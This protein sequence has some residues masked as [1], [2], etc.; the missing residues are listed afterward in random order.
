[1]IYYTNFNGAVIANLYDLMNRL[2]AR[3]YPNGTSNTFTYTPTG[4]RQTMT[5][6]S[7]SYT[8]VYDSRDRLCT[9]TTPLGT[10]SY[11]YDANGNVTSIMSSTIGGTLVAYQYDALNRLTNVVDSRLAGATNTAYD[12]DAVGNLQGIQYPNSVASQ[13]QYDSLNRLTSLVWKTNGTPIASFAYTLGASGNRTALLETNHTVNTV[14][15]GYA[16]NYDA[17]Y[18][19]TSETVT[20]AVPTG[21]IGY[22]YDNVGNRTIRTN[23]TSGL[24]LA[25][26]SFTFNTNDWLTGDVYDSNGNTRTNASSQPYFYDYENRLINFN[27]GQVIIVYD[28]DGNRVK[29]IT[30]TT[31]TLYLVDTHNPSGYAQVLEEFT[32]SG[33][34]TNL[35]KAY[36]Y[37]L[38]LISQRTLNPQP[39]T[40]YFVY[41]GHGSTRLL[42]DIGGNF[43]N[44]FAYDAYGNLIASNGVPQTAYLYCCQQWDPDLSQYYNR[45]RTWQP[46]TGRFWTMDSYTGNNEDPLSLHKYLYCQAD[47]INHTDPSGHDVYKVVV[48]SKDDMR[49]FWI[50]PIHHRLIVGDD[51][52][53]GSYILEAGGNG[54]SSSRTAGISYLH[55]DKQPATNVVSKFTG[56]ASSFSWTGYF[57]D[58]GL[59]V[60][61]GYVAGHVVTTPGTDAVLDKGASQMQGK[62][63][64][65]MFLWND[66]GTYANQWLSHSQE[67]EK[68]A[69]YPFFPASTGGVNYVHYTSEI[70]SLSGM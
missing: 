53:G 26:Q 41:D 55:N 34:V 14:I 64:D 66:C 63:I 16:W 35:A 10:L 11:A 15:R 17:M 54:R 13:Y 36:T 1:L 68:Q 18:R 59:L 19:L 33:G 49:L 3:I 52:Q 56:G 6:A 23:T 46:N 51:G 30:G 61:M 8:Y 27:N 48:Y 38:N 5:D 9:N 40:N 28:A 2:T 65:Y 4:Q 29:K 58:T 70:F 45:A 20:G 32:V 31:N 69:G 37:G 44:A 7:G 62:P 12:F 43:V 60:G 39:S 47:P 42:T 25:N 50:I 22:V 24:G 21:V 57:A 67:E